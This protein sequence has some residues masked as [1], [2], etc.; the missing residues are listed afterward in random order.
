MSSSPPSLEEFKR[1]GR[2]A[3][4][5]LADYGFHEVAP[6]RSNPFQVWFCRGDSFVTVH[7][8]GWGQMAD[9]DVE[10]TSGVGL[11]VIYL[12][13]K[14]A[15]PTKRKRRER[16]PSQLEQIRQQVQ[17]VRSRYTEVKKANDAKAKWYRAGS[18]QASNVEMASYPDGPSD[19]CF[20]V[21]P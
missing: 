5:Y 21:F 3:F 6:Q 8:E 16:P 7:G 17:D 4:G 13:P 20:L 14:E 15:R 1:E 11:A 18:V 12:V 9:A 19:N 10:H 2:E